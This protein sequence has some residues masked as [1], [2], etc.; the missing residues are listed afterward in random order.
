M[1][2]FALF[3]LKTLILIG[4]GVKLLAVLIADAKRLRLMVGVS[5]VLDLVFLSSGALPLASPGQSLWILLALDLVIVALYVREHTTFGFSKRDKRLFEAFETL[6]PGQLRKIMRLADLHQVTEPLEIIQEAQ[7]P[8][9]LY[10]IEGF[11]FTLGKGEYQS[12]AKGPA[13]AGEISFLTGDPAS[14]TV[15]LPPGTPYIA[16]PVAELHSLMRANHGLRNA[17]VARFSL[18]LAAKVARSMPVAS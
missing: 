3:D 6:T 9:H 15:T 1:S 10:Y 5:L 13:F 2:E 8:S 17:L 11:R 4:C 12:E 18:D 16:W 7:F 14:A